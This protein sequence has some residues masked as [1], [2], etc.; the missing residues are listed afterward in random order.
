MLYVPFDLSS[1]RLFGKL[2]LVMS[3]LS[4]ALRV[5]HSNCGPCNHCNGLLA[6]LGIDFVTDVLKHHLKSCQTISTVPRHCNYACGILKCL[7]RTY[8]DF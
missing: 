7:R 8:C 2:R 3:H 4:T 5:R 1:F 6:Q